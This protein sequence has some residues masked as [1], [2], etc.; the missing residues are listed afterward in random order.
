MVIITQISPEVQFH[1]QGDNL[2]DEILAIQ[3]VLA[4]AQNNEMQEKIFLLPLL[5]NFLICR[6]FT[7]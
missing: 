7:I 6:C 2:Q 4:S 1:W 3:S 5:N